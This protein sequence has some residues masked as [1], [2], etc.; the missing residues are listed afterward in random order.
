MLVQWMGRVDGFK[1][2]IHLDT[3]NILASTNLDVS[4]AKFDFDIEFIKMRYESRWD[5]KEKIMEIEP[6]KKMKLVRNVIRCKKCGVILE[7]MF[8][9]D[10]QKCECGN[11]V[12]GGLSY[13][14]LGGDL[15]AIENLSEWKEIDE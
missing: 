15:D 4:F 14:R 2:L 8:R 12:D 11:F 9:H 13:Q 5:E 6:V 3:G 10:F 1:D 7:S